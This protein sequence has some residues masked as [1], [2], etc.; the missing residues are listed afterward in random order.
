MEELFRSQNQQKL[1]PE[2]THAPALATKIANRRCAHPNGRCRAC[3]RNVFSAKGNKTMKTILIAILI[4]SVQILPA[5]AADPAATPAY[6]GPQTG[7]PEK[8]T[9][10]FRR[11]G[12]DS[13]RLAF[14]GPA[15]QVGTESGEPEKDTWGYQT[16]VVE[17]VARA[18]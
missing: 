6:I 13:T 16:L 9:V 8:D 3:E 5:A 14:I 7:N 11:S 17:T 12:D 4:A 2:S 15:Q 10:A 18:E 1:H